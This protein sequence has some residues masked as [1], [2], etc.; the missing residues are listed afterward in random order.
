MSYSAHIVHFARQ[1]LARRKED[2]QSQYRQRLQEA[3]AKVPRLR[4]IDFALRRTMTQAAQAVFATGGDAVAA[5][6]QVKK[7]NLALQ[8]ERQAL[9]AKYFTPGYLEEKPICD[10]CGGAG[11]VGSRMCRCLHT[12]CV[13]EQKKELSRLCT[14]QEKFENFRLDLYA[15]TVSPELGVSPRAV[16][17]RTY[18]H[19]LKYAESFAPGAANLLFNGGTGLGKTF[20]SACI[21]D[22]VASK[23][24]SVSYESAPQLF[25]K[26][27]KNR[28]APDEQTRA[29]VD[30][31]TGCDLL[32]V[33]DLGTEMPGNFVTAALYALLNDRLLANKSMLISTNLNADE[34]A[35][36]YSGQIASRLLG[37]FK[38]LTFVGTDIRVLKNRGF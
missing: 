34:M 30:A 22:A 2:N 15:D 6:E 18:R 38:T 4:E 11:F 32:I 23:G 24:F 33:D 7:E 9:E 8:Q 27:E 13:A 21:A 35:E 10:C 20:L 5:M 12:I 37:N 16:M 25:A 14:G 28:F 17:E 3:Y 36:R 29:E 26:L 19:C 1:E 31:I